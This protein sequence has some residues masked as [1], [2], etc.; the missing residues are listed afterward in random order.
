MSQGPILPAVAAEPLHLS[1]RATGRMASRPLLDSMKWLMEVKNI[2]PSTHR[3]K[4]AAGLTVGLF[5]GRQMMDVLTGQELSGKDVDR[6]KLFFA[7]RPFHGLLSYDHFSDDHHQRYM[8]VMDN[9]IPALMGGATAYAG[10]YDFG[11]EN[12]AYQINQQFEGKI[13][14]LTLDKAETMIKFRQGEPWRRLA[15]SASMF[16]SASGFGLVPSFQNYGATLGTAFTSYVARDKFYTPYWKGLGKFLSNTEG[17]YAYSAPSLLPRMQAYLSENVQKL[18]EELYD[19]SHGILKP[20]FGE[21][22]TEEKIKQFG[23]GLLAVRD[24]YLQDGK[25]TDKKAMTKELSGL[26]GGEGFEKYLMKLGLNPLDATLG[27]NGFVEF[28]SRNTGYA[29]HADA[30]SEGYKRGFA[31]RNGMK[32]V[33][34]P[35]LRAALHPADRAILFKGGAMVTGVVAGIG[36]L[37]V[38]AR[39][40]H[41]EDNDRLFGRAPQDGVERTYSEGVDHERK[42]DRLLGFLEWATEGLNSPETLGLH[43]VSCALGLTLF[44]GAAMTAMNAMTGRTFAGA[45]IPKQKVPKF[46]H[47]VYKKLAYNPHSDNPRD[48]WMF[49]FHQLVPSVAAATGVILASQNFFAARSA[50]AQKAEFI[51]DFEDKMTI[52]E[53]G[54]WT[55][56]TATSASIATPSGNVFL[57]IPGFNYGMSLGTR[58]TLTA[59]RKVVFPGVGEKWTGTASRF[60]LGPTKLRDYMIEYAVGNRSKDP[61]QLEEMAIGILRPWFEN[62]TADH[63]KAFVD[64]IEA[65]RNCFLAEGG[66]P[67]VRKKECEQRLIEHFKGAGLEQTLREI[68]LDPL[69]AHLGNN[70]I[71]A[72]IASFL[73]AKGKM[74]KIAEEFKEKY[75]ERLAHLAPDKQEK[76][77]HSESF[78]HA[79]RTRRESGSPEQHL[80]V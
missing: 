49:V 63:V 69:K 79:E 67:E 3:L 51:D 36:V 53:A 19:I 38:N 41:K 7:A 48:K 44:G 64:K 34:N 32:Y 2:D 50:K 10:S 60:P 75:A 54:P 45:E 47:G 21:L 66:I 28:F 13:S 72:N 22:A 77:A 26:L 61:E 23:D 9:W 12:K 18:P 55:L 25:V 40:W 80:A 35:E 59:G 8:H 39:R 62:I 73:G 15:G 16:G 74:H 78:A 52:A 30:V 68:G 1:G 11:K 33:P 6:D 58:Y 29:K 71:S 56:L 14:K 24:K 46:L 4:Q 31:T 42:N 65:D 20:W 70:G 17:K 57:P 76:H 43:R 27:R 37:A 5:A